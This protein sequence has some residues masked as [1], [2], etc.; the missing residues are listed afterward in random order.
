MT[1]LSNEELQLNKPATSADVRVKSKL[2]KSLGQAN[3]EDGGPEAMESISLISANRHKS[4]MI[5]RECH[6][7]SGRHGKSGS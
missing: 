3:I 4:E 7:D 2:N 1:K 6:R 5:I